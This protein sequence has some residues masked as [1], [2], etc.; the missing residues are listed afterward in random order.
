[1]SDDGGA[2]ERARAGPAGEAE[3]RP[4]SDASSREAGERSRRRRPADDGRDG[5]DRPR[6]S[7]ARRALALLVVLAGALAVV[8][9]ALVAT[10]LAS[11]APLDPAYAGP[12]PLPAD[13]AARFAY[14]EAGT[15]PEVV[16]EFNHDAG[17]GWTSRW[18]QVLVTT[19][20]DATPHKVQIIHHTAAGA[21]GRRPAVVVSPILGGRNDVSILAARALARRGF[22]ASVVLRAESLLD[23]ARDEARLE[24]V[25]RTAVVDRRRAIDWLER[26][27]E[28]DPRRIGAMGAST[29]ALATTALAAVDS[30]V[31]A[32]V[33]VLGGGDLADVIVR[34]D[35]P[36]VRRYVRERLAAGVADEGDLARRISAAVVS[37]PL[38]LAPHVDARRALVFTARFDQVVPFDAQRRLHEA[39]GR[40]EVYTL[41]TGHYAAA[42]LFPLV[43]SKATGF[44]E[45][46]LAAP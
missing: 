33:L 22:H 45:R 6:P 28:V 3:G 32:S 29:G 42:A 7:R 9:G 43:M 10:A 40:P 8:Y 1:M 15:A 27:P 11:H 12:A 35:E 44:L 36:R 25:L 41:P 31:R 39:L 19:P 14:P 4:A 20:G 46:A 24:R 37:D 21:A 30:R 23:G 38:R 34:A 16:A 13:V 18:V 26:Q 2:P 5:S 17:R